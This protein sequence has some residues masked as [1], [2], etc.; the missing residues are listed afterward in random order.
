MTSCRCCAHTSVAASWY[1]A[2]APPVKLLLLLLL[3]L[4][5]LL[6]LPLLLLLLLGECCVHQ[7]PHNCDSQEVSSSGEKS[8]IH[9]LVPLSE[10]VGT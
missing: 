8:T 6:L 3:L 10:L 2:T 5:L 7:H 4:R 1:A 9:A